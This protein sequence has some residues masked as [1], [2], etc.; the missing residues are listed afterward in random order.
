MWIS[1]DKVSED[2]KFLGKFWESTYDSML[3]N[4]QILQSHRHRNPSY[5]LAAILFLFTVPKTRKLEI[6]G[7]LQLR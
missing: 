1:E 3:A 5:R 4:Q 2:K 7:T 6:Q